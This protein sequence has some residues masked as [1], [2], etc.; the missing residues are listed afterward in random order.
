MDDPGEPLRVVLVREVP[1]VGDDPHRGARRQL[2]RLLGVADRDHPVVLAPQHRHR[3]LLGQVGPVGHRHDLAAPVD[4][5]LDHVA[6]R[7]PGGRVAEAVVDRGDLVEVAGE[8]AGQPG[9]AAQPGTSD[10]AYA[11]QREHPHHGVEARRRHGADQRADLAAEAAGGDQHHPL[12]ALGE[13]VGE[14]HRHAAAEAVADHGHLVDAEHGQ[15]VTHA[16][17]VAAHAVVGPR[18]VGESVPEQVRRDHGVAPRQGVDHRGPRRVVAAEA[19][20]QQEDRALPHL[21]ERAAVTVDREVG[22]LV[23]RAGHADQPLVD[24]PRFNHGGAV[25]GAPNPLSSQGS[26]LH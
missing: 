20:Q 10:V 3:H 5:G 26:G 23:L 6:D 19:V 25:R 22:D 11:R 7:V 12:G 24:V 2:R 13:L 17:G 9:E 21:H 1:G 14:L 4:D 16:V 18:L 15:Q 8:R